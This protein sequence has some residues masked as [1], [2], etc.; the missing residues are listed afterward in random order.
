MDQK[1]IDKQKKKVKLCAICG[2]ILT[3]ENHVRES[4]NT[5]CHRCWDDLQY[6]EDVDLIMGD[7]F[8]DD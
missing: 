1:E 4:G 8:G 6:Q 2:T 5:Y 7:P 3:K